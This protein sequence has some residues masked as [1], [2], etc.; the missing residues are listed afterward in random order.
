MDRNVKVGIIGCGG[1]ANGKHMP[2]LEK[3][4][5][6]ELVAFCDVL[7]ERAEKQLPSTELKMQRFMRIIESYFWMIL[8]RWCTYLLQMIPTLKFLLH[9]L[10][11]ENM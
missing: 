9:P 11:Q 5:N 10:I 6:V 7:I 8:S 1:I 2:S 3:L 4:K